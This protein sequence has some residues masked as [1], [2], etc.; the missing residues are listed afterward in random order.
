[1]TIKCNNCSVDRNVGD[2]CDICSVFRGNGLGAT[3]T[4]NDIIQ[5]RLTSVNG[6]QSLF[7]RVN[8]ISLEGKVLYPT[9]HHDEGL[10]QLAAANKALGDRLFPNRTNSS[11]FL[12]LYGE[13]AEMID[14]PDDPEEWADVMIMLLDYGAKHFPG[15]MVSTIRRKMGT[16]EGRTWK[17]NTSGVFQHVE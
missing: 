14:N 10:E 12:K 3:A 11:M 9:S 1:M 6:Q 17:A 4:R 16:N 8:P 13:I 2:I 15:A 7:G 5:A